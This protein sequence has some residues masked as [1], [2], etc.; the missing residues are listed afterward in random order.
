MN[1]KL[2]DDELLRRVSALLS[3]HLHPLDH[4]R[5]QSLIQSEPED[6]QKWRDECFRDLTCDELTTELDRIDAARPRD[7]RP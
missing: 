2:S 7:Q 5:Y 3:E 1:H 4:M 6:Y